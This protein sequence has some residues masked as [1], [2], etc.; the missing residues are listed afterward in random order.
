MWYRRN[1]RPAF[2]VDLDNGFRD[3]CERESRAFL[4]GALLALPTTKWLSHPMAIWRAEHK[5]YQ[6][7]VAA[8]LG[9]SIPSTV[10]TNDKRVA[11][12]FAVNRRLVAKAVSS[13]YV[14]TP[15]GNA[16]IFTSSVSKD[17]LADL[18]GL[19]LAPVIFQQ[20]ES[21]QLDVRVTVVGDDVFGVEI[22]SQTRQSSSIDW[23]ATDDPNLEHRVHDLP[24][25]VAQRCRALLEHL[26]LAFGAIDLALTEDG[27]YVFFEIN[28]N[29]EWVWLEDRLGIPISSAI[30]Q[31]LA[32]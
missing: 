32:S 26:G 19:N 7:A 31:W 30:A 11:Q 14:A 21:K 6:L 12:D 13:G 23:R 25:D 5:P 28:P 4:T 20:M 1:V 22:L 15:S 24:F 8:Q 18:E 16:A 29:G 3:L 17:D 2:S 10:I 27:S 9:F